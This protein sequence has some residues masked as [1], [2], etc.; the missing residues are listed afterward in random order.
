MLKKFHCR[1]TAYKFKSAN[2]F[3]NQKR[4]H[5]LQTI[6]NDQ[7]ILL[8]TNLLYTYYFLGSDEMKIFSKLLKHILRLPYLKPNP[9][10][11]RH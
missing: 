7:T 8:T 3:N 6:V 5:L 9:C 1:N 10:G 2:F 11:I 4:V